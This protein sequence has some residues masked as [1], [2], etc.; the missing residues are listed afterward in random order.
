MWYVLTN[1]WILGKNKNKTKQTNKKT[2]KPR[3]TK[4]LSIELTL[5]KL[6]K[7]KVPSEDASDSL[8]RE[9]KA[10]TRGEGGKDPEEKG[11]WGRGKH[12]LVLDEEKD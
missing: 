2:K 12:D 5:T 9:K 3:I 6:N 1:K 4:I 8:W 7:L 10:T 11:A